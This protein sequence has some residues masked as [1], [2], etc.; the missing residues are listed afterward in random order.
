MTEEK[1]SYLL[2]LYANPASGDSVTGLALRFG[3]SKSTCS[4]ILRTFYEEGWI[5]VRGKGTLSKHGSQ[6]VRRM[7]KE[8]EGLTAWLISEGGLTYSEAYKEAK[9]LFLTMDASVLEKLVHRAS[10][11]AFYKSLANVK[12]VDGDFLCAN[13]EDGTYP[14]AFTIYKDQEHK[15]DQ[16]SMANEGFSHPGYLRIKEGIGMLCL[17]TIEVEHASRIRPIV[18][19]GRLSDLQYYSKHGFVAADVDKD[20]F[21]I[22][23]CNI[24]FNYNKEERVLQGCIRLWMRVNVGSMH[25]PESTAMMIVYFK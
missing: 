15:H 17:Q 13:L 6:R 3:I 14:F 24:L 5:A 19:K 8:I 2:Y 25:M 4:R 10:L 12:H 16:I 22:P 18:L 1:L 11:I 20:G 21:R 9:T 7:Q 23:I